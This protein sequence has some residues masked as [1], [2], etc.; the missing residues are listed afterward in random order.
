[1]QGIPC[2]ASAVGDVTFYAKHAKNALLYN[3]QEFEVLAYHLDSLFQDFEYAKQLAQA[4]CNTM[5][6]LH[7]SA[8]IYQQT[9]S[10]YRQV[11]TDN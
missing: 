5:K 6:E 11:L 4:G 10:I 1:M 2:V 8:E 3:S 7:Q 9:V